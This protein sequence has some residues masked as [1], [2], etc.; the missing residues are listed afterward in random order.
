MTEER[1]IDDD[2]LVGI[3]GGD[4]FQCV[5]TGCRPCPGYPGDSVLPPKDDQPDGDQHLGDND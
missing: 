5:E 3:T 4:G 1:K 2:E